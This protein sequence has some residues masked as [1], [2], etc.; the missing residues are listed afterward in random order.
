M[1]SSLRVLN[2]APA[3][4]KVERHTERWWIVLNWL[5]TGFC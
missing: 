1:T 2:K 3:Y 5:K 4:M